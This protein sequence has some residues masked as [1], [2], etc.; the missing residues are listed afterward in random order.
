LEMTQLSLFDLSMRW[1]SRRASYRPSQEPIDPSQFSV[2][3]IG[4]AAARDFVI[5]HHYSGS[6]PAAIAA[7]GLF[8]RTAPFQQ[9]LVGVAVFSVPMQPRAAAAYG[10]TPAAKFCELGRFVLKDHVGGNG[11]TFFLS[12]ALRLLAQDKQRADR[13]P[14]YDLCLSYSDPMPRTTSA[15]TLIHS[16]HIG[17]IYVA[18]SSV[19]VGRGTPRTHWLTR[20]GSIVS[21]RAL[22]KLRNG[23]RGAA[24]AYEFLRSH[25]APARALGEPEADYIRRALH[26]GPFRRMRH[27]G[28]HAYVFPCGT[29]STRQEI[30]RRMDKGLPRPTKTDLPMAA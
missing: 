12:K 6:Y 22:S 24:Y 2:A 17:Q 8:E 16:G 10:A 13:R 15:G 27:N 20:D 1:N 5:R 28:N 14:L 18:F 26:E 3:P 25:G 21:P 23:E 9:E 19:Y 30:R 29:H 11:E 7:Y 4:D